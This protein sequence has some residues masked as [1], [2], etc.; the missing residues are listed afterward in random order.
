MKKMI[1]NCATCDMRKVSEETLQAYEQIVVNAAT[2]ADTAITVAVVTVGSSF[3]TTITPI[4]ASGIRIK[5][6]AIAK[7][8]S[9][10]R[11]TLRRSECIRW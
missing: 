3:N 2:G 1:V 10:S 9:L 4:I 11:R 8:A 7:Y 6:N 5:R